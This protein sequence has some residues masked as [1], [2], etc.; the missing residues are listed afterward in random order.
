MTCSKGQKIR[1]Q[2]AS[3]CRKRLR[4]TITNTG[5]N[6]LALVC[7]YTKTC[8]LTLNCYWWVFSRETKIGLYFV[9]LNGLFHFKLFTCV[10][11]AL[12]FPR[13]LRLQ[14]H[15]ILASLAYLHVGSTCDTS[16]FL[17]QS[18]FCYNFISGHKIMLNA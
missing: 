8:K 5:L 3:D 18:Y 13:K 14:V 7:L 2:R 1:V 15:G 12:K 11:F 6:G 4:P 10:L 9:N 17:V 16:L